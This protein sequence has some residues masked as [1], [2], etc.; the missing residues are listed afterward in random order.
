MHKK[1]LY[2]AGIYSV[3]AFLSPYKLRESFL[4]M[5]SDCDIILVNFSEFLMNDGGHNMAVLYD[6]L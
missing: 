2:V 5:V 3:K 4:K 6:K 1:E